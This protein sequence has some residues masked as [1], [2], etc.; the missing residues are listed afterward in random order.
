VQSIV[1]EQPFDLLANGEQDHCDGC[2][3]KTLW[4]DRLVS[5]CV[6]EEYLKYGA[7][8]AAVPKVTPKKTGGQS[9]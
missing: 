7:P 6:L 1:I 8:A 5:A 9:K 3:N 2:P 4:K